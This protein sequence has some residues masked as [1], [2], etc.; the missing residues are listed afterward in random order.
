MASRIYDQDVNLLAHSE[1]LG[2]LDN[3]TIL[4]TGSTGLIGS[5]F[6]KG[7]LAWNDANEG[8]IRVL[9]LVRSEQ[10]AQR[11]FGTLLERDDISLLM[12]D[13]S[14][15][16]AIDEP[17]DYISHGASITSSAAFAKTPVEVSW[18][19]LDGTR[20]LLELAR[21]KHV[22]GMVYLSSLE[23]YGDVPDG[24][25]DVFED[26]CGP[27]DRFVTRNSYPVAKRMCESLCAS[28]SSEYGVPVKI[29]R[30]AQTFGAGVDPA[31]SRVFAYFAKC[32]IAGENIVMRTPGEG[33]RCYCY[34]TDAVRGLAMLAVKG[35]TG[36]AYNISNPN[37]YCSARDMAAMVSQTFGAGKTQVEFD[38]PEDISSYGFAAPSLVK[39]NSEKAMALGWKPQFDLPAMYDRLIED[40]KENR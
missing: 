20:N 19:E 12:G 32:C 2:L 28:Y 30:L 34:T 31:D 40:L 17:I 4:I 21:E 6:V 39:L 5:L 29:A 11:V 16:P 15:I 7:I 33:C 23:V 9:A 8:H 18:T 10:K 22:K 13:T 27:L 3:A 37:T 36:Q 1:E 38:M 35:E 26:F 24:H 14:H 25:G